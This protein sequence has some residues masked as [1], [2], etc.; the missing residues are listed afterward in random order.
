MQM[1]LSKRWKLLILVISALYLASAYWGIEQVHRL[2]L[3]EV[4]SEQRDEMEGRV[5]L[6]RSNL[7]SLIYRET[8][9]ADSL[10]TLVSLDPEGTLAT[11]PAVAERLLQKSVIA[12]NVG[13]APNDIIQYVH[14]LAE[15]QALLGFDFRTSP[16]QYASVQ[17]ARISQD[18]YVTDPVDLIQGGR[19]IIARF[20]IFL[21]APKNQDYWGTVS[22][23]MDV[24]KIRP[25]LN[26]ERLAD[27]ELA[28]RR[29]LEDGTTN[30]VFFGDISTFAEADMILP[31]QIPNGTWQMAA[32]FSNKMNT[33]EQVLSFGIRVVLWALI[34]LIYVT[35]AVLL[36]ASTLA[37]KN[38][39]QDELTGLANRRALMELL[40]KMMTDKPRRHFSLIN[41]DLNGFK[42]IN[43]TY[44]HG[45]GD[46][47]L[48]HFANLLRKNVRS[49]D[50]PVRAGGDE[51][52][53]V[54]DRVTEL[55]QLKKRVVALRQ[56]LEGSPFHWRDHV[57]PISVSIGFAR[58]IGQSITIED[59][60]READHEMYTNKREQHSA[61]AE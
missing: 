53:I 25:L 26:L 49:T 59:L 56:I 46:A 33:K 39:R 27:T 48:S 28:L 52:L 31:I 61:R 13:V 20:P 14:P 8:Y 37:R 41:L 3:Q 15:N 50:L 12:R 11:W 60:L 40:N 2:Y 19:G 5:S 17:Q 6:L 51:F 57:I 38:A 16:E 47:Y 9:I 54:L 4:R 55:E 1:R 42:A 18:V 58:F 36:R 30:A 7:Q 44:G 24:A 10:A 32:T 45:V 34:V 35:V 43:D 23:V 29:Q 21:D 22:V